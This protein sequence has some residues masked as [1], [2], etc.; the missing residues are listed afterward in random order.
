MFVSYISYE[1]S[2]DRKEIIFVWPIVVRLSVHLFVRR[3]REPA[4]SRDTDT[5]YDAGGL[6]VLCIVHSTVQYRQHSTVQA[7]G[8]YLGKRESDVLLWDQ[9]DRIGNVSYCSLMRK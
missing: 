6:S 1:E 5:P 3:S 9:H 8:R 2:V 7:Q 4:V